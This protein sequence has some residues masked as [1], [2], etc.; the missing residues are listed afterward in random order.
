MFRQGQDFHF[1]VS[2]YSLFEISEFQ[3]TR[4]SCIYSDG[5][6]L[7]AQHHDMVQVSF[8]I[9]INWSELF[10]FANILSIN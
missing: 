9:C 3:I 7:F 2:G 10:L 4:V 1:E 8:F 5:T 6:H